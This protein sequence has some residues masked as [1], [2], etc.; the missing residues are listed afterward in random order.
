[1][2]PKSCGKA[3]KLKSEGRDRVMNRLN[4][5]RGEA[6]VKMTCPGRNAG[7]ESLPPLYSAAGGDGLVDDRH[8]AGRG[9]R[10]PAT[11]G[12]RA[13]S[14]RL[15][16]HPGPHLLSGR[17]SR[18]HG[19]FRHGT[20]GTPVRADARVESNDLEQFERQLGHYPTIQS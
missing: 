14:G 17:E 12:F 2:A 9:R 5:A 13:A 7:R 15:S 18:R 19:V 6:M 3:V 1:M 8:T 11:P 4:K 10:L 20:I 16:H